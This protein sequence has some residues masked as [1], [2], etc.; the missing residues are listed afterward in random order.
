MDEFERDDVEP[1][2]RWRVQR[3]RR[4]P[5][6]RAGCFV[7][8]VA[9]TALVVWLQQM[10]TVTLATSSTWVEG[11]TWTLHV[12]QDD[13]TTAAELTVVSD[14]ANGQML[15][16]KSP[17]TALSHAFD[18][19]LPFLGRIERPTFV[20]FENGERQ[21]LFRV[22][23]PEGWST[24]CFE[25]PFSMERVGRRSVRGTSVR[26]GSTGETTTLKVEFADDGFL[27]TLDMS[28]GEERQVAIRRL[29]TNFAP[30]SVSWFARSTELL[31]IAEC[32]VGSYP[33]PERAQG[34]S[35]VAFRISS[36]DRAITIDNRTLQASGVFWMPLTR[37]YLTI[38]ACNPTPLVVVALDMYRWDHAL[39]H[40]VLVTTW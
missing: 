27:Q 4:E 17:W 32:R 33:I 19:H 30:A 21:T 10:L 28:G 14:A 23:A 35:L 24:R 31:R 34:R 2:E 12:T 5:L 39:A 25:V 1:Q 13:L 15:A 22:D 8:G 38:Q 40:P 26:E 7:S 18:D 16:T 29:Y 37:P 3:A 36:V 20:F 6:L 11:T 9:V